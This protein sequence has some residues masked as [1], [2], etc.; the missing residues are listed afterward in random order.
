MS[1]PF[2]FGA[3]P[4]RARALSITA[5]SFA[6]TSAGTST[7]HT[8]SIGFISGE[9]VDGDILEFQIDTVITFDGVDLEE[10]TETLSAGEIAGLAVNVAL[11]SLANDTW[12]GRVRVRRGSD[13]SFWSEYDDLVVNVSG[14]SPRLDFSINTNSQYLPLA[15]P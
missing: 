7:P 2:S 15:F 13:V 3:S 4:T 1:F 11:A 14:S 12:Y 8:A 10:P 5:L 6:W 9:L